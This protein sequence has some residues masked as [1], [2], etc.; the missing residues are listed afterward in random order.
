MTYSLTLDVFLVTTWVMMGVI[1]EIF[2]GLSEGLGEAASVR[3]SFHLARGMP[4][5]AKKLSNKIAYIAFVLVL[6]VTSMFL[7]AGPNIA[8][9][10]TTDSTIQHLFTQLVGLTGL[11]NVSMTFAQVYWSLAGA[12]C[13]FSLA[14]GTILFCRWI[15]ILPFASVCIY[16]YS[17]DLMAVAGAVAVGYAVASISLAWIVFR[18][19]WDILA[20]S[21][22]ENFGVP[23]FNAGGGGGEYHDDEAE[24][25][26]GD[27]EGLSSSSGVELLKSPSSS[28]E[29]ESQHDGT[30]DHELL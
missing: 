13:R 7:M 29:S 6:G 25:G 22:H 24:G 1:W 14:S 21:M 18:S 12:Q 17:F 9:A 28:E 4:T 27:D 30:D 19:D 8:V 10:L 26:E 23:N 16:R 15:V 3:V 5:E 2:A 11:A 20:L